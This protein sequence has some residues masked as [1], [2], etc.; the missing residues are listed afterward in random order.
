MG[1]KKCEKKT[2]V[3]SNKLHKKNDNKKNKVVK[4]KKEDILL[5]DD[6]FLKILIKEN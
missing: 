1:K 4:M 5:S 3:N 6:S 2:H